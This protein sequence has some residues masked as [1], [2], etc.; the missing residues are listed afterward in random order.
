MKEAKAD[1]PISGE[2]TGLA[3]V[4]MDHAPVLWS[5][6]AEK[7]LPDGQQPATG[8][9]RR[10]KYSG[11]KA[12]DENGES[13]WNPMTDGKEAGMTHEFDYRWAAAPHRELRCGA[14][15]LTS[16]RRVRV[17]VQL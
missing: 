5:N 10:H 16:A 4:M 6:G 7:M 17:D 3:D 8:I 14:G 9:V 15:S 11:L 1:Q 13:G 12:D 2:V